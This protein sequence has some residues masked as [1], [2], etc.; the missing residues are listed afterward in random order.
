MQKLRFKIVKLTT[1][2]CNRTN[3]CK[4]HECVCGKD[5]NE[6][7]W[8][9]LSCLKRAGRF[10]RHPNLNALIE[11]S[12]SSTHIA[13]AFEPRQHYRTDQKRSDG[14]TLVPW[15]VGEELLGEVTVKD[16]LAPSSIS[17]VSVCNPSTAAAEAE[18][19]NLQLQTQKEKIVFS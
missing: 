5:V 15:D 10:S 1:Q 11:Q 19:P 14:L 12:L 4:Q 9:C 17:A 3:I 2:N 6:D 16:S 7:G 13:S 8:H 18:E